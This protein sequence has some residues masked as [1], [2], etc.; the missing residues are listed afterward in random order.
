MSR[1]VAG[2]GPSVATFI[3]MATVLDLAGSFALQGLPN[4]EF[5]TFSMLAQVAGIDQ[6]GIMV[7]SSGLIWVARLA[8]L[9]LL[10]SL[11]WILQTKKRLDRG[12]PQRLG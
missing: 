2:F 9:G 8:G 6:A 3:L 4:D 11:V 10:A 5:A 12:R 1:K 7:V